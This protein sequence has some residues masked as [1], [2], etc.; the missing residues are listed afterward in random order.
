MKNTFHATMLALEETLT[1]DLIASR[2]DACGPLPLEKDLEAIVHLA[3]THHFDQVVVT[4]RDRRLRL[5]EVDR[6]LGR[7]ALRDF[8]VEDLIA[9]GTPIGKAIR[10]LADRPVYYLLVDDAI[11]RVLTRADLNKLPVQVFTST[12]IAHLE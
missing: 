3:R 1:C 2:L 8:A 7:V 9:S 10:L 5:A 12:V 4:G 11:A 6:R